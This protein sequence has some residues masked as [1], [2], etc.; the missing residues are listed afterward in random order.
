MHASSDEAP[1]LTRRKYPRTFKHNEVLANHTFTFCA[2]STHPFNSG[3]TRWQ[4]LARGANRTQAGTS[5]SEK[6][7]TK[8]PC[9]GEP[10]LK[11]LPTSQNNSIAGQF[12]FEFPARKIALGQ[13]LA[14][15][16]ELPPYFAAFTSAFYYIFLSSETLAGPSATVADTFIWLIPFSICSSHTPWVSNKHPDGYH[17]LRT[18]CLQ[19]SS[20]RRIFWYLDSGL[21]VFGLES[22]YF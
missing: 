3:S 20:L 16:L 18:S 13:C 9:F 4:S 2:T 19:S 15:A 5:P 6:P 12:Q 22:Y 10:S 1:Q 17:E 7:G 11:S 14:Y 21:Y 8:E